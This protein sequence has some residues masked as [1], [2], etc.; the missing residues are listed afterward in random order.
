MEQSYVTKLKS[1][2]YF[3]HRLDTN[4][5]NKPVTLVH[6]NTFPT[7]RSVTEFLPV[8]PLVVPDDGF[9]II[10]GPNCKLG[11]G[12]TRWS[13]MQDIVGRKARYL[14]FKPCYHERM[15]ASPQLRQAS[16]PAIRIPVSE[17]AP[18]GG[19]CIVHPGQVHGLLEALRAGIPL[20]D[21]QT[22]DDLAAQ[23]EKKF[24]NYIEKND[25]MAFMI[26]L[27]EALEGNFLV[28]EKRF[29]KLSHKL[30][31]ASNLLVKKFAEEMKKAK[32]NPANYLQSWNVAWHF[33]MR[34]TWRDLTDTLNVVKRAKRKLEYLRKVNHRCVSVRFRKE[35]AYAPPIY[36]DFEVPL[37]I[38]VCGIYAQHPE[39]PK[40]P[41]LS[42]KWEPVAC[43]PSDMRLQFQLVRY[44]CT[45]VACDLVAYNIPDYL[46]DDSI[47]ALGTMI[48]AL[49][50]L[51]DPWGTVWELFPYSWAIDKFRSQRSML[52]QWK[53]TYGI[54]PSLDYDPSDPDSMQGIN[55]YPMGVP[56]GAGG[57]SWKIKTLWHVRARDY[58]MNTA[59]DLGEVGYDL[60]VRQ[61]GLPTVETSGLQ[62]LM[63]PLTDFWKSYMLSAV[64]L[65]K[66]TR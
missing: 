53:Q 36:C 48:T 64:F 8:D 34:T 13:F 3:R 27:I 62:Y 28:V 4:S 32:G 9:A 16:M 18:N 15:A 31:Q 23:A 39:D 61:P 47:E 7:G 54:I 29:E 41:E 25:F 45:F 33:A 35:N 65:S 21:N 59:D 58:V 19:T 24:L 50:G 30:Q 6:L 60:Y 63:R 46:L 2:V 56:Q 14:Y 38:N 43:P 37:G 51:Y 55:P 44:E 20:P 11:T 49:L 22:Q 57:H 1:G 52:D 40:H 12:V 26:E 17:Y 5:A 42:L 66:R 10:Q